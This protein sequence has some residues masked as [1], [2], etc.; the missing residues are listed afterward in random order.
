MISADDQARVT[1]RPQREL[2]GKLAPCPCS[3]VKG[4]NVL[5]WKES[6]TQKAF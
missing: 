2:A 3:E 6:V 4:A 5:E 1:V